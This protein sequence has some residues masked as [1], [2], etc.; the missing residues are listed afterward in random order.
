[1]RLQLHRQWVILRWFT[2]LERFEIQ[3]NA[4]EMIW[5]NVHR[6][7]GREIFL[8]THNFPTNNF[9]KLMIWCRKRNLRLSKTPWAINLR[10]FKRCQHGCRHED[11]P[12]L[13]CWIFNLS[14]PTHDNV[15]KHREIFLSFKANLN[16]FWGFSRLKMISI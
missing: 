1:M 13:F 2:Q 6:S 8:G 16:K 5:Q 14:F 15:R 9:S 10:H 11:F 3:I 12:Q 4:H 7:L